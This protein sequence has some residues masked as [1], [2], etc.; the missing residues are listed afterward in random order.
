[1]KAWPFLMAAGWVVLAAGCAR[2]PPEPVIAEPDEAL[3]E[4]VKYFGVAGK[5]P[6]IVWRPSGLGLRIIAPGA[7][8]PPKPTDTVRV[9]YVGRL[10]DGHVFDDSRARGHPADFVV[11]RL[12][13][14]WSVAM[15]ALRPGGRA[16]I[17]IPPALGYGGL[18]SGDIP[19]YSGLIFDVELLAVN[20]PDA[21]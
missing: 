2:P 4:H 19:P 15:P 17:F 16:E 18:K 10:K 20:P 21:Q 13:V 1:M 7:G 6:D 3:V 11:N 9:H 12:I 5:A 8:D 14:G